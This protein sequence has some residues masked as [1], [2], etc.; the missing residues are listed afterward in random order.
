M[1]RN[2]ELKETDAR[3]DDIALVITLSPEQE[4]ALARLVAERL[5]DGYDEGFMDVRGTA[6][7]LSLTPKAIYAL[8]ER[9]KL[10]HHRIGKRLLF[11]RRELRSWVEGDG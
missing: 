2:A 10:P 6:E 8:V 9:Q 3:R 1:A 11:D 7:Y 4:E 5:R